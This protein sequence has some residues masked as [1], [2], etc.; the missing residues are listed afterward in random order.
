MKII[1]KFRWIIMALW[2]VAGVGL[3]LGA[4]NMEELVRDKGQ[5]SVPDG[6]SS[7]AA[8]KLIKE[9]HGND[10]DAPKTNSA[11]LVFHNENGLNNS[12]L[13]KIKQGI[14][15]L[16]KTQDT[17]GVTSVITHFDTP[18]LEKQ[19][20]SK[21][22]ATVMA[23]VDIAANN[24]TPA[25]MRDS[26]YEA[27]KGVDVTHYF[28]GDW[29]IE[30]DVV[31]SS[32]AGLKKTEM[33]T[34]VFI[35]VILFVVFRSVVAPIIP[36]ITVGLSYL[37]SQSVVA[38]LV[39]Y[40]DFPLSN[41]TQIFMVAV[42]FG[43]GTDYCIL[44]IS[45]FKEELL[46]SG[47]KTEAILATYRTAGKTV[48]Y[49]GLA[50]LVG[51]AS[52][53]FSTFILYRSA[54]AVAV[55]VAVLLIALV[56]IVP[57]F[58][59]V[60]GKTIFWPV[61]GSLEHKPS[62]LWGAVGTFSLKR[63]VWALVILAVLIVPFLAAYKGSVSFNSLDE[64]GDKYNSV[65]AF[66]VISDSFGPGDTLAST[67]VVKSD[68]PLDTTAGLAA[69]E[70]VS[71]E[72]AKIDG[73]KLV[74]SATRPAG[75]ELDDFE[76]GKQVQTLGD[77]LGEGKDGLG[78]IGE[79]LAEASKALGDNAPKLN[80]A[81]Q[82]A[83]QL[84]TGTNKLKAGVS[85]LG[86]GLKRIEQGLRDGSAGAGELKAGLGQAKSSADQLTQASRD[87]LKGYKEMGGGI[88]QLSKGYADVTA[89][90]TQ[91]ASQIS[92]L[93]QGLGALAEKHP[94][95][96]DDEAYAELQKSVGILQA[97]AGGV[98]KGLEQLNAQLAGLGGG[99]DQA[100]SGLSQ[101]IEGQAALAKGLEQLAAGIGKLQSG[102]EQ[103]ANGQG[104]IVKG[105]P[106][107][108]G[109]FDQLASGQ[110]Q[111]QS[112]FA[113]LNGQLSQL[114]DGLDQSV[115]GLN[116]VSG[117]L[118]S[119]Q[120]YLSELSGSPNRQM[121]GWFLPGE[122]INHKEFQTALD[123]YLSKD[124]KI[125][126]FDVVFS[127]NPYDS[128]TMDKIPLL[129]DAAARGLKGTSFD[130]AEL[131]VG[132][133]T[134]MNTDLRTI[135]AADYSRTVVFMMIGIMLILIIM[136]R[137][138]V[139]PIYLVASLLLT[140]YTSVAITELIFVRILGYSGVSWAVPFFGFVLLV[141]LGIDYSIF[142]MDRFKEY[143]NLKPTEAILLSMKNMGTVIMSAALIL[144][145]TFA[146]MLPSGVLSLLQIATIV[147]CG[148]FLY[149]LVM[150]PLFVPVMVRVF[151]EANWWPFMKRNEQEEHGFG[152][153]APAVAHISSSSE[154]S[155]HS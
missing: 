143:R 152:T 110:K 19:L 12:E 34:L 135:S 56:T 139:L 30:E 2:L 134:S 48:F 43:I 140:Y 111:L 13:E 106:A 41:F 146:A 31:E 107:L 90:Q 120:D 51:F 118:N 22:G 47:S 123:V 83:A 28:T 147:L 119:A 17:Y 69:I 141:A 103:A 6:Y 85:Q 62:K 100:N 44:L 104:Q 144:G 81:A 53:G 1:L 117:G 38:F 131:A 15:G 16:K 24:R 121:T 92:G 35:L 115:D 91:L 76:V 23:L 58:L 25:E 94:E 155:S 132:G 5:I 11:V 84:I 60:L 73:V 154:R 71:R 54:V 126:K 18:E 61:K 148:L 78:K 96:K 59:A 65:K 29:L 153:G 109:G 42:M 105:F 98:T 49:S 102:I 46:H 55:G 72:L 45:R 128:T 151:G 99:L 79:G 66:Q 36:L 75:D 70:Q 82:G 7:S 39:H 108:T 95:L 33:I 142:L 9:L 124:R 26:L 133:V 114:T 89:L 21:D 4:P 14:E 125:A 130:K 32:Q 77:G 122:V 112:G 67:V 80:E 113:Q 74:R 68:S 129:Q 64:I 52:I 116:K 138:I 8:G 137:S 86:D 37:V 145:G 136:F 3:F 40:A 88:S 10:P 57:F 97:T 27:V 150:L 127:G 20:V 149:A 93:G 63:P 50:V 87:L 101:A